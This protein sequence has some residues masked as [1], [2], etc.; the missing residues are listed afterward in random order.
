MALPRSSATISSEPDQIL[1]ELEQTSL[2]GSDRQ[3]WR[4]E[5]QKPQCAFE[6]GIAASS[7]QIS[8]AERHFL[9]SD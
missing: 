9:R 1:K 7:W 4:N 3:G 2:T 5:H 8:F 6:S